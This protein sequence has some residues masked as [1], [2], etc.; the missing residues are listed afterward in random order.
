M[1]E[2]KF[3]RQVEH[4]AAVAVAATEGDT[5]VIRQ[6]RKARQDAKRVRRA[7]REAAL[8][9]KVLALPEKKFGVVVED[10]E[11][12]Q[13]TWSEDGK[14][15]HA[16]NHYPTSIDAHTADEIV[17]RTK[18]RF[19]CAADDCVLF[20]WTTSPHLAIAIDVMRRRG[21]AYKSNAIWGKDRIG[22]GYWFRNKHEQLLVGVRGK[23][24]CP[25]QGD[26]WDSLL[27]EPVGEHSA[28]PE[29]FLEM[30]E[31]Y[32]P[33]MPK[34]ELNRRGPARPG[35]DAWGDEVQEAAE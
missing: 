14:D 21:F 4:A 15:R 28:K 3:E 6:A 7:E 5:S 24:P 9:A 16:S 27:M 10:Y 31:Q 1:P 20:M 13:Q 29:A 2:E 8:A 22:T 30:I 32:F 19:V 18:G 26:Q 33:T 23:V 17:E 34:I 35:W 11:W 12:D 25:A